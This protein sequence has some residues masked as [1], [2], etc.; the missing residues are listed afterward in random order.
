MRIMIASCARSGTR[1]THELMA[2]MGMSVGHEESEENG[3]VAHNWYRWTGE[4]F[5]LKV[6]QIRAPLACIQSLTTCRKAIF[7]TA[8]AIVGAT[9][10]PPGLSE[11]ERLIRRA[12]EY[13]MEWNTRCQES[14]TWSYQVEELKHGTKI[15][16]ALCDML[17]VP[18]DKMKS[19]KGISRKVNT[20]RDRPE[21]YH[22]PELNW[23]IMAGIDNRLTEGI[24]NM[25]GM[26]GYAPELLHDDP[27][28]A[29]I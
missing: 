19:A 24:R 9:D 7:K 10:A 6:H 13:W 3:V 8:E 12:M 20:R 25:A 4:R 23:S 1:Y 5:N 14:T 11:E 21:Q 27:V 2:R 29:A 17:E 28:E 15:F 22:Y 18:D 16:K 26:Y